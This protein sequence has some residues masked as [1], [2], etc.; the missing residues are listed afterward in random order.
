M[1]EIKVSR[2]NVSDQTIEQ[3]KDSVA[4]ETPIHIFLD[5]TH[6]GTILCSPDQLKEMVVE[7]QGLCSKSSF[8]R[9]LDEIELEKGITSSREGKHKIYVFK[10]VKDH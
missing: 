6:Y 4:E 3:H 8:Y 7:E 10:M 5:K 1:R 2:I 9:V